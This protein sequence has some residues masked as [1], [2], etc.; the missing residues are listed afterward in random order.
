MGK[1][2]DIILEKKLKKARLTLDT[3]SY[4]TWFGLPAGLPLD[5][6]FDYFKISIRRNNI[7]VIETESSEVVFLAFCIVCWSQNC[8]RIGVC[9]VTVQLCMCYFEILFE[10]IR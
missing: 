6:G 10:N 8:L 1:F 2:S 9:S 3:F 4:T 5:Y 7:V